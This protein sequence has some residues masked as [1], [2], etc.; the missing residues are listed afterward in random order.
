MP[1]GIGNAFSTA[2]LS[3]IIFLIDG[4]QYIVRKH[5][6]GLPCSRMTLKK[7]FDVRC[8]GLGILDLLDL[9]IYE[10]K[11]ANIICFESYICTK[12]EATQLDAWAPAS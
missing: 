5:P 2:L 3:H 1:L 10:M 7:I 6:Y 8:R 9:E 4:P 12:S 11:F